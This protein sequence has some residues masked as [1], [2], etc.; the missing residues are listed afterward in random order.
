MKI[1]KVKI[2]G[3]LCK[4]SEYKFFAT[5]KLAK[6]FI[7]SQPSHIQ[8][9][10]TYS[11]E[12]V[13]VED[14]TKLKKYEL[15][16]YGWR[17]CQDGYVKKDSNICTNWGVTRKLEESAK[18]AFER[19]WRMMRLSALAAELGGEKD[20]INDDR[21]WYITQDADTGDWI[22]NFI[23]SHREPEKVYMTEECAERICNM[24]N[25][26]EFEL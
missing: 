13:E 2:T 9:N 8:D 1:Y 25:E 3:N 23:L 10:N 7:W 19:S 14:D 6:E 24:L 26:G 22:A 12:E 15:S 11:I 21:N 16:E 20:F 4:S 18:L 5:E 17:V